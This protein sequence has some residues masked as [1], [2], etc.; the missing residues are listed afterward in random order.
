MVTG[1]AQA[2]ARVVLVLALLL[3]LI[4]VPVEPRLRPPMAWAAPVAR[5]EAL[6]RIESIAAE[7]A[8]GSI[9]AK[10]ITKRLDRYL[11]GRPGPVTA[12]V[13]DLATGRV[14]RYHPGERLITASSAKVQILMALLLKTPWKKLPE[15]VRR[16]ADLMIRYS[17]NHAADRLWLRIGGAPGFTKA[18]RRFGLKHTQ[19][20]PG[21]CLDLYCWGITRTSVD[22]QIRL[23]SVLV[24]GKSP[25]KD[26]ERVLGLMGKVVDGQNWGISAAACRGDQVALKNGWLKRVST[27]RWAVISVGLIRNDGHDYAVAVLTEGSPDVG[28][29]IATVEGVTKRIMQDFRTCPE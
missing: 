15:A 2:P 9:P 20:V 12:M 3:S 8:V 5:E 16:D 13:K 25:L 27:K 28:Y 18:G 19:G 26:R 4:T 23:M 21:D 17:D 7:E 29:G 22:D 24:S 10:R 1:R 6:A 11:A 14:Y